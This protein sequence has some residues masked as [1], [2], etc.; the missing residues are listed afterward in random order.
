MLRSKPLAHCS[1]PPHE[2]LYRGRIPLSIDFV[3]GD[4]SPQIIRTK[5]VS[6]MNRA[7]E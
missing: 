3:A 7:Y 2:I 6:R 5:A 1:N 4:G